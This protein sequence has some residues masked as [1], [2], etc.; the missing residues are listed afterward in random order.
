MA[1]CRIYAPVSGVV[2]KKLMNAG[3]TALPSQPVCTILDLSTVK[4]KASI[5]EKEI[6]SFSATTPTDIYVAALDA[7]FTGGTAEK[8]VEADP[9]SRTYEV[10]I[11]KDGWTTVT[12]DGK[13]SAHYENTL[14]ITD[15]EPEILTVA[16]G[17]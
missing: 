1:D 13:L 6:G 14:L 16:E 7:H 10:R 3:E 8:G 2:G 4:V 12:A 5:P 17:Q 9:V 15:G 11:L